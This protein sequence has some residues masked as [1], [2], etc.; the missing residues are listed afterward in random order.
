MIGIV[1][2]IVFWVVNMVT[3]GIVIRVGVSLMMMLDRNHSSDPNPHPT[4][5]T[6]IR[7]WSRSVWSLPIRPIW[8]PLHHTLQ[9]RIRG[10]LCAA[11]LGGVGFA[12]SWIGRVRAATRTRARL[13]F[14]GRLR[15]RC[16]STAV[17]SFVVRWRVG[18]PGR[19]PAQTCW[20]AGGSGAAAVSRRATSMDERRLRTENARLVFGVEALGALP[21][22]VRRV[23]TM[24]W[25]CIHG[26]EGRIL[27]LRCRCA[28]RSWRP[29][30]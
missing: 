29:W 7:S 22:V 19:G 25:I 24:A 20:L 18:A 13:L 30:Q 15:C 12:C 1:I 14:C 16:V 11:D 21:K 5:P 10:C 2:R 4:C 26:T 17:A 27:L 28:V 3:I 6:P 23:D 9:V 8:L